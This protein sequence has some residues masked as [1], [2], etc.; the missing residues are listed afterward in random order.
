LRKGTKFVRR[1]ESKPRVLRKACG[2][3]LFIN[4]FGKP[5]DE[6]ESFRRA[7]E[8]NNERT[9][10]SYMR[11]LPAFFLFLGENPDLVIENRKADIVGFDA[12]NAERYERKVKAFIQTLIFNNKTVSGPLGRIHGFFSNNS[13]RLSLDLGQ[14]KYPQA[15]KRRKY[16]P[17][18]AD[19]RRLISFADSDRDKFIV[20]VMYQNGPVPIDVSKLNVG[21]YPSE[22]W[23][24]FEFSR[25][26]TGIVWRGVSTPDACEFLRAYMVKRK[27][28]V[29][30]P[31]IIGR[32][33]PLDNEAVSQ[34]VRVLIEKAGLSKIAGFVPK[35]LRDGF[36]DALADA[37][38]YHKTKEALM[39]H[40]VDIQFVYGSEK[41]MCERLVEAMK[42]VF[43]LICL[44]DVY[45]SSSLA[46]FSVEDTEKVK[47][48][49]ERFDD[50]MAV[51]ELAKKGKILL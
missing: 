25:S 29:G 38:I 18:N 7:V 26:K 11:V 1:K 36:E 49:L 32:E 41:R 23:V 35:C 37:E 10:K 45:K 39:G 42:K 16:S 2:R 48:L 24:Y 28:A 30:E 4:K 20:T 19:V 17:E 43:P 21:D 12:V 5:I 13:H 9:K 50:F 47:K 22:P 6:F 31:L 51:A 40:T 14:F 44:S 34:A 46:G 8:G 15:R 33:G 3:Q 27:G